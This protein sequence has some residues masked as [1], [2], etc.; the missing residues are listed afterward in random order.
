MSE[1]IYPRWRYH[2]EKP[3]V[4]VQGAEEDAALG[5]GWGDS[6]IL[7]HYAIDFD[8]DAPAEEVEVEVTIP[9][10]RGRPR[11]GE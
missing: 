9:K 11:K 4:L 8:E 3:A 1:A 5:E 2:K 7:N 10:K 6:T